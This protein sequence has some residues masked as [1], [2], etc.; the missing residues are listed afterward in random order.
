MSLLTDTDIR[1]L[2]DSGGLVI[3]PF[4]EIR[5]TPIGYNL[6]IGDFYVSKRELRRV[7]LGPKEQFRVSPGQAVAIRTL[8]HVQF[9]EDR[10]LSGLLQSKVKMIRAGF[11]PISST[12]DPE[13]TGHMVIVVQNTSDHD[14]V[15]VQG[16]PFCTMVLFNNMSPSKNRSNNTY[17][18]HEIVVD[19]LAVWASYR[20][21][22]GPALWKAI[23][24]LVPILFVI[25]AGAMAHAWLGPT[26]AFSGAMAGIA[27]IA[28]LL[29]RILGKK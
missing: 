8:E 3:K 5:L 14:A 10:R 1:R 17:D 20:K 6:S 29:D 13:H 26:L 12:I 24:P 19:L 23:R 9:P 11:A 2:L 16:D 21:F 27:A 25:A 15:L 4:Q 7:D 28:V 22:R 18:D